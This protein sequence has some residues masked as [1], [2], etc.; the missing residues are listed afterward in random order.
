MMTI[1]LV[2]G[3]AVALFTLATPLALFSGKPTRQ[4]MA[5][6][7]WAIALFVMQAATGVF[8]LTA[9]REGPGP[10]HVALPLAG[11]ALAATARWLRPGSAPRDVSILAAAFAFAA[12]AAV[13]ALGT[14]LT[15]S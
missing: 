7:G 10:L 5:L 3:I 12:V 15:G 11:L 9:T 4:V 8:L 13:V 14:G 2:M 1:H 6:A